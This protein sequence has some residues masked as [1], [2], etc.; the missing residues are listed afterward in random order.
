MLHWG[1]WKCSIELNS[2]QLQVQVVIYYQ[3]ED[4]LNHQSLAYNEKNGKSSEISLQ[5]PKQLQQL[6]EPSLE[7]LMGCGLSPEE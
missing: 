2:S 1:V 7:Q 4:K 6:A 3:N 5:I